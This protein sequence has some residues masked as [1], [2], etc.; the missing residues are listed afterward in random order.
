MATLDY[1]KCP[2]NERLQMW[3]G[4]TANGAL[5]ITNVGEPLAD[6]LNNTGDAS[7]MVASGKAI[8]WNDFAFGTQASEVSAEPSLV[9]SATFEEFGQSNY[10]GEVSAYYPRN[11]DD[12]SNVLSLVYDLVDQPGVLLDTAL[13]LDGDIASTAAAA[14][15]QFVGVYRVEGDAET[16]PFTPGESKRYTK[17]LLQ[18]SDFAHYVPVGDQAITAIAPGSFVAGAKGRIRASIQGRDVTNMLEFATTDAEVISVTK[19]GFFEVT[20]T[21]TDTATV[22]ISHPFTTD[23]QTAAVT[24]S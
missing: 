16:N 21:A 12:P 24:V 4:P 6:E 11:Y 23:T 19:G 2:S 22:T 1:T 10:G 8:S 13:R 20:G 17:T 9:D 7:G 3:I 18:K 5:G 15:G 14:N